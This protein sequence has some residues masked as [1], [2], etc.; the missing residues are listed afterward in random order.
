[1]KSEISNSKDQKEWAKVATKSGTCWNGS[2]RYLRRKS[3]ST[4]AEVK[5]FQSLV[6][7]PN[8]HTVAIDLDGKL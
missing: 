6:Y 8:A 2:L 4:L 5:S 7:T 1:M 3:T